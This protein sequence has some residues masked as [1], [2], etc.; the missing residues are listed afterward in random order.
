MKGGWYG[1]VEPDTGR[2]YRKILVGRRF[3][4]NPHRAIWV[5]KDQRE[6]ILETESEK[7]KWKYIESYSSIQRCCL[8]RIGSGNVSNGVMTVYGVMTVLNT[9]ILPNACSQAKY[10][11]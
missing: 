8:G 2:K 3:Y 6:S 1:S 4:T 9:K 10:R 7:E 5:R 11:R